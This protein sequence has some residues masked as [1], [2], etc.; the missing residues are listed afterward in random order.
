MEHALALKMISPRQK[1]DLNHLRRE[2]STGHFTKAVTGV[3]HGDLRKAER[4][5][6]LA[7]ELQRI[8]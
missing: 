1:Q 2:A 6:D 4:S 8:K 7:M 5:L 3:F